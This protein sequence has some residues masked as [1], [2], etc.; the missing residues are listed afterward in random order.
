[1]HGIKRPNTMSRQWFRI[2]SIQVTT[3]KSLALFPF[4]YRI[5][6]PFNPIYLKNQ[7][8]VEGN[9]IIDRQVQAKSAVKST[10][11]SHYAREVKFPFKECFY[12]Y[13]FV[14][15]KLGS[16]IDVSQSGIAVETALKFPEEK[17]WKDVMG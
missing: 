12:W 10:C 14:F 9:R 13:P 11:D 16:P 5:W 8:R 2:S 15:L 17:D 3:I 7:H 4:F 1:M 6:A